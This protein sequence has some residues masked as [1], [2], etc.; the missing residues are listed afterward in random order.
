MARAANQR[1]TEKNDG[2]I[3]EKKIN[4]FNGRDWKIRENNAVFVGFM[5]LAGIE[6]MD[7]FEKTHAKVKNLKNLKKEQ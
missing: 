2:E 5:Y 3:Q 4:M 1:E 6:R 7:F